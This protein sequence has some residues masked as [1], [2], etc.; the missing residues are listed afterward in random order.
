[1]LPAAKLK[2]RT[3]AKFSWCRDREKLS[4]ARNLIDIGWL[5]QHLFP[6]FGQN[7]NPPNKA[8]ALP[9]SRTQLIVDLAAQQIRSRLFKNDIF[10]ADRAQVLL[11]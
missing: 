11:F 1:M 4:K 2:I 6:S 8:N 9:Q 10:N 3:P 7:L 5:I